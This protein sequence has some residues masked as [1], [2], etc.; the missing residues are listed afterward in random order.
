MNFATTIRTTPIRIAIVATLLLVSVAHAQS[1][2]ADTNP[3]MSVKFDNGKL[4][5]P[6]ML[7]DINQF[8]VYPPEAVKESKEGVVVL[9]TLIDTKGQ[10]EKL[11][12]RS[13]SDSVF[14]PS[15]M[16]AIK[17][18]RF[19]PATDNGVPVKAWLQ[20]PIHYK[21]HKKKE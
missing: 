15:A 7:T 19:A 17:K 1:Q 3:K 4:V 20:V 11:R 2:P 16:D 18:V 12:L 9:T 8:V 14:V 6:K 5:Q 10:L 21:L 13:C